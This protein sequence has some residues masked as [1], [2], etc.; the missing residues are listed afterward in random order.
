[1]E[2]LLCGAEEETMEHFVMKCEG[3][4]TIQELRGVRGGVRVEEVLLF[5]GR[6][7]ERVDG[8]TKMLE[9]IWAERGRLIKSRERNVLQ[10]GAVP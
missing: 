9:E 8:F 2:C 5:E 6:T 4:G 3:I 10:N 1:M 7:K